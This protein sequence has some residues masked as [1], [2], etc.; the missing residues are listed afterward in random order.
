VVKALGGAARIPVRATF[1]GIAY[2]GSIVSMGGGAKVIGVLKSIRTELGVAPGDRL[3]VTVERDEA[4]RSVTVPGDLAAALDAA[5]VRAAFDALSY[6][7]QR[8]HVMAIEEAKRSDTRARR[9]AQ[10]VHHLGG[11]WA[12]EAT[13]R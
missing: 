11:D 13:P 8:E 9:V 5:G 2:S 10:T 3:T 12:S 7:H 1:N 6:S 4:E